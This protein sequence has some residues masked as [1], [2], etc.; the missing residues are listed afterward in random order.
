MSKY[1]RPPFETKWALIQQYYKKLVSDRSK[2]QNEERKAGRIPDNF[3]IEDFEE[4]VG[5]AEVQKDAKYVEDMEKKFSEERKRDE[6]KGKVLEKLLVQQLEL[7]DWMGPDCFTFETTR[8]DDI[9]NGTDLVLEWPGESDDDEPV[10]LCVD[11]SCADSYDTI[12]TKKESVGKRLIDR[13]NTGTEVKY[14]YSEIK[15]EESTLKHQPRVIIMINEDGLYEMLKLLEDNGPQAL[16]DERLQLAILN[17]IYH[18]ICKQILIF[19][20][21][22]RNNT[23]YHSLSKNLIR[24]FE[25]LRKLIKQKKGSELESLELNVRNLQHI[26]IR[27]SNLD[28][29]DPDLELL[30][31]LHKLESL[32]LQGME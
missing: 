17:E 25:K 3:I 9:K 10:R 32:V 12:M 30:D 5:Q 8:Y 4:S 14:F 22:K 24:V 11:V 16:K 20:K 27:P 2:K 7:S 19:K 28:R 31:D 23:P 13:E 6:A 21:I 18:Q 29:S 15:D 26:D 1:E